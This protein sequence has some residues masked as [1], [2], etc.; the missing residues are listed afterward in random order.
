DSHLFRTRTE[1]EAGVLGLG[2]T[3]ESGG[4][5]PRPPASGPASGGETLRV[6]LPDPR[7]GGERSSVPIPDGVARPAVAV[8][9]P[10]YLPLYEAKMLHQFDHRWATY[11]GADTR[12][13][14]LAQKQDP[15]S[16][17]L[18]R[19]WVPEAEVAARLR[20]RWEHPWLL[21]WRDICRS[22]DE[23]TVI[24]GI[25][26]R[27]AVGNNAPLMLLAP[28]TAGRGPLLVANLSSFVLDFAARFKVG[29]THLNFFIINQIPILPPST[30]DQPAPWSRFETLES[31]NSSRVLQ[32]VYTA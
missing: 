7:S 1:L 11:S 12:D 25:L 18:P 20:G 4:S 16:V 30:Y 28:D 6:A 2:G 19:Y 5:P 29:G 14:T 17:A 23:R 8:R 31:W 13:M 9:P 22:T 3:F 26:P 10:R 32:L 24:A 21:G 27:A 15:H